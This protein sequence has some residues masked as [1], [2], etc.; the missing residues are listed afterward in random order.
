M[1]HVVISVAIIR[2]DLHFDDADAV[3]Y[4]LNE[5]IFKELARMG[6]EKPPPKLTFYKAFF[7]TQWKFLIHTLVQCLSAKRTAWN[8]F[9]CSMV[10]TVIC[11]ATGRKFNFSKYIFDS[12]EDASKQGRKIAVIDADEDVTLVDVEK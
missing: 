9:S 1:S 11:L 2:R 6:Y 4:F 8:E 5:E 10:S 7:S 3:D 12:M